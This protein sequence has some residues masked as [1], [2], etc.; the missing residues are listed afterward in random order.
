MNDSHL[1][2]LAA[3][4]ELGSLAMVAGLFWFFPAL[5]HRLAV[6]IGALVVPMLLYLAVFIQLVTSP[7]E[8]SVQW[9]AS[10][11]WEMT[12]APFVVTLLIGVALAFVPR[13]TRVGWRIALGLVCAPLAYALLVGVVKLVQAA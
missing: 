7:A 8:A 4:L 10:A 6:L 3:A 1:T 2:Y 5:R 13:P 11:V 12:F 9:V